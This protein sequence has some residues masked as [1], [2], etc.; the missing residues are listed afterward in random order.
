M[1]IAESHSDTSRG[2]REAFVLRR[3]ARIGA[4]FQEKEERFLIDVVQIIPEYYSHSHPVTLYLH[5]DQVC[6]ELQFHNA[7]LKAYS[8]SFYF[9]EYE[10]SSLN[11]ASYVFSNM[12]AD[13]G[14][15]NR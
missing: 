15:V 12:P 10:T 14:E 7:Y 1:N 2:F 13:L 4:V 6:D 8:I 5:L 11:W 3:P 9:P